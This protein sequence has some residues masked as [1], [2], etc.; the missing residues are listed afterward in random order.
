MCGY[1]RSFIPNFARVAAPLTDL[2]KGGKAGVIVFS[3]EQLQAFVTLKNLLCRSTVLSVADHNEP[4]HIQCDAS[5]YAVGA[6]VTQ[7]DSSGEERPIAFAS[8]K[9]SDTQRRWSIL[10]KEAYAVVYAL[11]RFDHLIFGCRIVIYTDHDPL[12]YLINNSPKCMKLT[13]WA[14]HLSR[15]DLTVIH[16]AGISNTNADCLSRLIN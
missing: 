9:L 2:T 11:Q 10:E 3:D 16:K 5:E 12:Q 1:Y 8:S 13:R 6:C 4:F 15:Y 7:L 14:L